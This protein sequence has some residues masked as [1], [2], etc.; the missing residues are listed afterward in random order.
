HHHHHHAVAKDSTES[1]SWEPFSL[2]PIKDPQALHKELCS[3][4][5]IPVTSTLEDLLPATQAQHVFIKRG[6]FHSYNWTI[7][8][9]SLNMDR[10]RETCQSLVDRHSILR[11]SFVEHEGHP[12]QLVLANL[13]VKVREVQCWPGE[14]PMEVCKALWDGKDW[15]T[16][17]VL[18]GSLPVRF[19][20]VSCPGNEHV[21]LTIQIS[22]SQWDGVS[23]PKLFSDFAAIYNQTPL[24]PT[25]DFA[26]Y[27]YHRVSS[28]REDV[29]QD[30]TFQ[31]W[32][33]YLDGAKMAVPFAPRAL[34]LCAEPAAAAQSG[35]TLW[36][37]KGIVPPTLPSGITMATLVK[38][39]TALFL[40]YHLGSRDVVFGHTVN[41]RNLPMDNIESLLGCT[42]NFVPLRVTFPEDSTDWTV[43][44]LLHHTQTQ[45]T[46]ALSHEHVELR[47]IFQHS[48]NWPAETPLSLIVQH[49]NIDL[50]FSLPLRGSSVSGDGEDDSS[51]DVQ[52][53]KFARFDPLDEVWIFTEPHADRLEVQVCANSR[54][55][56][57]EQATELANNISA[58]ITK[59]STDPTARLLDI[60]F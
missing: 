38:A 50:S 15:P 55:L 41:G 31:F 40:S 34:T 19:T 4:N 27:L 30:P 28:A 10:L 37:F 32:R 13:D 9:R 24:P 12:I 20:L 8:G 51:L 2:S 7:K 58:I 57:Q 46:R 33:H 14:D 22:H 36:T 44:D 39:A 59:F 48:T 29:Q 47:D 56:G 3:K 49:Q 16:L 18:G 23:I 45:Y 43:M 52:Y 17:N 53:S 54:V 25:S 35:Q 6:T 26:H 60:T 5:V 42:L 1:K 11:T 21:V